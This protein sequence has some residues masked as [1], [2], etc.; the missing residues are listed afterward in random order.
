MTGAITATRH[1]V[2]D[3]DVPKPIQ[4]NNQVTASDAIWLIIRRDT[5]VTADL[6][7]QLTGYKTAN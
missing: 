7:T 3:N 4:Q 2:G 1:R 5:R 6:N